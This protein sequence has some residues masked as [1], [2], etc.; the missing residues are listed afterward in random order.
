MIGL[1]RFGSSVALMLYERGYR[2]LGIDI[3]RMI[4]QQY[5]DELTRTVALDAT[6]EEALAAIDISSFDTVVVSMAEHFESSILTTVALKNLGVRCVICKAQNERQANIL[7]LVGAD[8]IVLPEKEAGE[9]LALELIAPQIISSMVLGPGHSIAE[10]YSPNWLSGRSLAQSK[11]RERLG[12]TVLAVKSGENLIVSPP[13][14]YVF[15]AGDLLVVIGTK[16]ALSRLT[17]IQ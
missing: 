5:S 1:G 12:V 7:S 2:V 9:R 13:R 10:V 8:Q 16:P 11:L 6:D 14:D 15:Q 4:V 17:S 3:D